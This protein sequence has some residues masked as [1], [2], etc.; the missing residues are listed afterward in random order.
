MIKSFF[1]IAFCRK[2]LAKNYLAES[3]NQIANRKIIH[4]LFIASN[5]HIDHR[6]SRYISRAKESKLFP[7]A[8]ALIS[9]N[10][11]R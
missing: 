9:C 1:D 11:D 2:K 6:I 5:M 8:E 7:I 10:Q 3:D 4:Q